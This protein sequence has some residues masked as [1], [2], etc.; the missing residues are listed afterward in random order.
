MTILTMQAVINDICN[1]FEGGVPIG[2]IPFMLDIQY[3][4]RMSADEV[5]AILVDKKLMPYL[6]G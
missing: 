6:G 2:L 1:W 3:G 4:I 5:F